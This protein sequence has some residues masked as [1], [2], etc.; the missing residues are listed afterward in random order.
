ML[1]TGLLNQDTTNFNIWFK[2]FLLH[3]VIR[4]NIKL[5]KNHKINQKVL[6]IDAKTKKV[7]KNFSKLFATTLFINNKNKYIVSMF[8]T[9]KKSV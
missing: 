4:N 8:D 9:F 6:W 7:Q 1:K 3:L 5:N 2:Q